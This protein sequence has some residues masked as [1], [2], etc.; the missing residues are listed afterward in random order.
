MTPRHLAPS[1]LTLLAAA[2]GPVNA[3]LDDPDGDGEA[4]VLEHLVA[5]GSWM[6]VARY[7][8]LHLTCDSC[9]EVIK[10]DFRN[11]EASS[12]GAVLVDFTVYPHD[13]DGAA[14]CHMQ[15]TITPHDVDGLSPAVRTASAGHT[16]ADECF[17]NLAD[18]ESLWQVA[19]VDDDKKPTI[20][21]NWA[22]DDPRGPFP[23]WAPEGGGAYPLAPCDEADHVAGRDDC[24]PGCDA[25][26]EPEP[27]SYPP[28]PACEPAAHPRDPRR[29]RGR[30]WLPARVRGGV[31]RRRA[32]RGREHRPRRPRGV[33]ARLR[34]DPRRRRGRRTETARLRLP[35]G[36]R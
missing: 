26:G 20:I 18:I 28:G 12:D 17:D 24:D 7:R 4:S 1:L 5:V 11:D 15:V 21:A 25:R 10:W 13:G 16:D 3:V 27:C 2:C 22:S 29:R 34:R 36:H 32:A 6:E 30:R 14:A 19:A 31:P 33:A 35:R 8:D 9:V 23:G